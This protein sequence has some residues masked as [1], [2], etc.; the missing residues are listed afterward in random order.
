MR[1]VT[2]E[3]TKVLESLKTALKDYIPAYMILLYFINKQ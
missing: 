1:R 3:I 2:W